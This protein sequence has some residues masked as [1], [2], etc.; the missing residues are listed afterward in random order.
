MQTKHFRHTGCTIM[1]IILLVVTVFCS[2]KKE[3]N[4]PEQKVQDEIVT[5][6]DLVIGTWQLVEEYAYKI[7]PKGEELESTTP[8]ENLY[9]KFNANGNMVIVA[10][11][12]D[13][14]WFNW[15]IVS[16]TIVLNQE[17]NTGQLYSILS[18]DKN[19]MLL[20]F[21]AGGDESHR[22]ENKFIKQ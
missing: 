3:A 7:T 6:D 20:S 13:V 8:I 12:V 19:T 11:G 2:C 18:L 10:G 21:K 4:A 14:Y 1:V 16:N 15:T 5:N 17:G 22:Y 9:W